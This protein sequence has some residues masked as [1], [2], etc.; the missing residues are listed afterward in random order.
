MNVLLKLTDDELKAVVRSTSRLTKRFGMQ[1]NIRRYI[2]KLIFTEPPI[3]LTL[4]STI[5][6]L[7]RKKFEADPP[8]SASD[9]II[10]CKAC[11]GIDISESKMRK[12][13][14]E[15]GIETLVMRERKGA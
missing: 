2:K 12:W 8:Y 15:N 4:Q 3:G 13:L 7:M 5:E 1:E 11:Y 14:N 9:A 10:T 6:D